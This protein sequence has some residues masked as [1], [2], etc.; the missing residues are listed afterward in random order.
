MMGWGQGFLPAG[1]REGLGKRP[2]LG[3]RGEKGSGPR[4]ERLGDFREPGKEREKREN[5]LFF[6]P[7]GIF[8]EDRWVLGSADGFGKGKLWKSWIWV[9]FEGLRGEGGD[10]D[11]GAQR[12]L[13]SF[14][15]GVG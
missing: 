3:K 14:P 13:G 15:G 12:G 8:G 6:S 1:A 9:G 2:E 4:G 11:P 7:S 5:L 10:A